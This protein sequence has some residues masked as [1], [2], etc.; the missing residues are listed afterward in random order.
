MSTNASIWLEKAC[1]IIGSVADERF[2]RD[3]W[4][5]QGESVSW[6]TEMYNEVFDDLLIEDF[7]Q[8]SEVGLNEP[9]RA[10]GQAFVEAMNAFEGPVDSLTPTEVIDHPLWREVRRTARIFLDLLSCPK[11]ESSR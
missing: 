6:P 7:L 9:Q 2:Q 10:A 1:S 8:S 4:F 3:N 11:R 5:G